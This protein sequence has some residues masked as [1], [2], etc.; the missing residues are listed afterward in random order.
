M[1]VGA[2]C[3]DVKSG[4]LVSPAALISVWHVWWSDYQRAI[5]REVASAFY[6]ATFKNWFLDRMFS[7][8]S[9][10]HA[11]VTHT[12]THFTGKAHDP[13]IVCSA[14]V[15]PPLM[16]S[17]HSTACVRVCVCTSVHANVHHIYTAC[18]SVCRLRANMF[19]FRP[20]PSPH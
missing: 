16:R 1:I 13:T 14:A 9:Q 10:S 8:V 12:H 3:V 18:T 7:L 20:A 11:S 4:L 5:F 2:V 17:G 6:N 19:S 15:I